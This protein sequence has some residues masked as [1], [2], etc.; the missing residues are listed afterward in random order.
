M[1][2]HSRLL[3]LS[4]DVSYVV[5]RV[6]IWDIEKNEEVVR[7]LPPRMGIVSLNL[8]HNHILSYT[9]DKIQF[10]SL[11]RA[12]TFNLIKSIAT[13]GRI[14]D[15]I[16][17]E[18]QKKIFY[19]ISSKDKYSIMVYSLGSRFSGR[20]LEADEPISR[21]SFY[22]NEHLAIYQDDKIAQVNIN[23]PT[24]RKSI[25][26]L[27]YTRIAELLDNGQI[28]YFRQL[29][30]KIKRGVGLASFTVSIV[31]LS[32]VGI[33]ECGL[34]KKHEAQ[35]NE[36]INALLPPDLGNIVREYYANDFVLF[37]QKKPQELQ[38][39]AKFKM[40]CMIL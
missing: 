38:P 17:H 13:S 4:Y 19:C 39:E 22:D 40:P 35:L 24:D 18:K 10:Y 23:K 37:T 9:D 12:K 16:Y 31:P 33:L 29:E 21:L 28:L 32:E 5:S 30:E 20:L 6:E 3:L 34:F 7:T 36:D 1:I 25:S 11:S 27:P 26:L 2:P 15:V 14:V 8:P